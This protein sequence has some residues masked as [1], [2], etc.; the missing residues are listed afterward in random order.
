[1]RPSTDQ[2]TCITVQDE[3]GR[4]PPLGVPGQA[5]AGMAEAPVAAAPA[6]TLPTEGE[7]A[8]CR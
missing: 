2:S 4:G 3:A 5:A 1:M 8:V 6:Q 7:C